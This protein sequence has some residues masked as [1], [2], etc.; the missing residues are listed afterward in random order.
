MMQ[1]SVAADQSRAPGVNAQLVVE[2]SVA[3]STVSRNVFLPSFRK[4]HEQLRPTRPAAPGY[5]ASI[6]RLAQ[7][8][9]QHPLRKA[10]R[11][12]LRFQ[13]KV[14]P[15]DQN[16]SLIGFGHCLDKL[17]Q[18]RSMHCIETAG[19]ISLIV[20]SIERWTKL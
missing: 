7:S 11:R 2:E 6:S 1:R 13:P 10:R 17:I 16:L 20:R 5:L 8:P 18:G 15:S 12:L 9:A 14:R 19:G 4:T 3:R